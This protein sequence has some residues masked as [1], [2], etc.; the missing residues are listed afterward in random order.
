MRRHAS[1]TSNGTSSW[2]V[3]PIPKMNG[4]L[5]LARIKG[6]PNLKAIPTVILTVSHSAADI[7]LCYKLNA[8]CYLQKPAN[9]D[10]FQYLVNSIDRFWLT[11]A[12]FPRRAPDPALM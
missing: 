9:W 10:E 11:R 6:D 8:N 7:L 4:R 2:T 1:L 12:N 5:V 3:T